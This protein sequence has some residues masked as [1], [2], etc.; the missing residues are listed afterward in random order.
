M[1]L[2]L[3][4]SLLPQNICIIKLKIFKNNFRCGIYVWISF[5]NIIKVGVYLI[6]AIDIYFFIETC[7][8]QSLS[9]EVHFAGNFLKTKDVHFSTKKMTV[10]FE[11]VLCWSF[12]IEMINYRWNYLNWCIRSSRP[13]V[14]C[15]KG[16]LENFT[17]HL[18]FTKKE[19]LAQMFFCEFCEI[20]KNTFIEHFWWLL[21]IHIKHT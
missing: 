3:L 19:T 11:K 12:Y 14:Y 4:L 20:L 5:Y 17:K 18:V 13:E 21:L 16:V 10:E 1:S 15:E 8:K 2:N 6:R 9:E 7:E